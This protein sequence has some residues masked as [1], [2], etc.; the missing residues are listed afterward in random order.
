VEIFGLENGVKLAVHFDDVAFAEGR[1]DD[2]HEADS[3]QFRRMQPK[4]RLR[5]T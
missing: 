1:G 4:G 5:C 3:L 2:F